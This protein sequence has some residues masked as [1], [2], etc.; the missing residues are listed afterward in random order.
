VL[1]PAEHKLSVFYDEVRDALAA[2]TIRKA[3]S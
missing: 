2:T 3:V 1:V